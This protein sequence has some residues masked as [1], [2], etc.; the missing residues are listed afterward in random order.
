MNTE[1]DETE[2]V[3]NINSKSQP[4]QN[5]S[6]NSDDSIAFELGDKI[7]IIGGRHDNLKGRIYYIDENLIRVLPDGLS[8][9]LVDLPIVDEDIDPTLGVEK[10][11]SITKRANPAFVAQIDARVGLQA[12][13]FNENG[14]PGSTY[15]IKAVSEKDDTILLEDETG[16]E[17]QLEFAFRGIP[18][19]EPFD[20]IRPRQTR[21]VDLPELDEIEENVPEEEEQTL[22]V[23]EDLLDAEL[24]IAEI[25]EVPSSQRYY[26]DTV[27]RNDMLQEMI[28]A[29]DAA[30]QKNPE[31]Q[32]KIRS[33]VEQCILL[34]NSLVTY[35]RNGEP[36][37]Q[38]ATSY[39]T[40]SELL[41]SETIPLSRPVIQSKRI[42]FLD[43]TSEDLLNIAQGDPSQDPTYVPGADVEIKY[44]DT[45]VNDTVKYMDGQLGGN[46]GF[47][48]STDALPSWYLSWE[49]MNKQ[50]NSTWV[51]SNEI[52]VFQFKA[53]KEFLRGIP[54]EAPSIDGLG[55]LDHD[56]QILTTSDLV[57]KIGISLMRGLGP[58]STRLRQKEPL[59]RIESGEEGGLI[60][61]LLFPLSE[62]R[63]LG[64]IRSGKIAK[65]IAHSHMTPQTLKQVL[66]RLEGIPDSASAGGILSIGDGGNTLGNIPLD[67]WLRAL[68]LYPLGLGD[69]AVDLANY[70]LSYV[71]INTD[72]HDVIVEK[73]N[74]YRALIKQFITDVRESSTKELSQ[75]QSVPNPFLT[76]DAS[77]HLLEILEG[78]PLIASRIEELKRRLPVYKAIDLAIFAGLM[79]SSADL[80]LTTLAQIPGPLARERNRNV[81]DQF[82]AA[83]NNA[84]A[85]SEKRNSA[86]EVP[87]PNT[88]VHVSSYTSIQKIKDTT[89]KMRAFAKFLTRFQGKRQNNWVECGVCSQHL[90]C[91]HEV[92]LLQEFLHPRE[93]DT[94]HKELLLN[95]SGG[96][97]HGG[98]MCK[99]CGQQISELE[100]D[101]N[102]E[103]TES[104]VP[105]NGGQ[106]PVEE[107][108]LDDI[109][110]S[111]VKEVLDFKTATQTTIY[112]TTRK[113]FDVMGINATTN[114]YINI[115]QRVEAEILR[116]PS[117]EDYQRTSKGKRVVDYDILVNRI[118]V[119]AVGANCL[120]EIQTNIPGY[121]MRSKVPGCRAGFS[122]YPLGNEKDRT[123]IEYVSCVIATIQEDA[124]PW[125][126]TGFQ[127]ES[128]KKRTESIL[129][130]VT[131]LM[132]TF[133][134]NASVQQQIATK[135]AHLKE[136][137]GSVLYSEQLPE[138]I[139]RGFMPTPYTSEETSE[140]A[141]VPESA[142]PDQVIRAWVLQAHREGKENGIFVKGMPYSEA[143]CCL[144]EINQPGAFWKKKM[145]SM[146]TL[147]VKS[148]PRG[149]IRSHLAIH[150]KPRQ[151]IQFEGT[152]S[153]EVMYKIFLN[154]CY[155]GPRMG[156]PHQPGYTNECSSC[157][158][159]YPEN[160]YTPRSIPPM[161]SDR[162]IQKAMMKTYLEELDSIVTKGK[163]ALE[164]QN[165]TVS[166]E[167]FEEVVDAS[168]KA[169]RVEQPPIKSPLT[170]MK[171]FEQFA[172]LSPEPFFGW[173]DIIFETSERLSRLPPAA[174]QVEIAE[175]YGP[176]SNAAV[177]IIDEF[178]NRLGEVN[179]T[180]IKSVLESGPTELVESVR[181]Y[182]LIPFQRIISGFQYKLL[183]IQKSYKLGRGTEDDIHKFLGTH[184]EY[185]VGLAKRT[186]GF[187]LDKMK[188][189]VGRLSQSLSLLKT[190]IRGGYIPGGAMGLPFVTTALIGGIL[191]EFM[192][193][194]VIPPNA[195]NDTT[196]IDVG[197]RAPIQIIDVC[198][199][200]L[201]VEGLNFTQEQIRE[202]INR[203]T[204]IESKSF[205]GRFD[206]LTPEE[207]AAE[208]MKKRLGLGEWA[209]GGTKAIYAYDAE[210]YERERIQ[211]ID[212]GFKDFMPEGVTVPEGGE[213]DGY[214]NQQI[215]EDDY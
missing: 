166:Q 194:N 191:A 69:I 81:R 59:R 136:L 49:I 121:V 95:F 14:E 104:G 60:N 39:L 31:T 54:E 150:F 72:Q 67:E 44:L 119:G 213:Q 144:D 164:T 88:C 40:L 9:R 192:N 99:N 48:A 122:G 190:S 100:F 3:P 165:I 172:N 64:S 203:R 22:D 143:A 145:S 18:L 182:F 128:E 175:A 173:K 167:T 196:A 5:K 123:G 140:T 19:D 76:D 130:M 82:L 181:T 204:E 50:F 15:T 47:N 65:D 211:R 11:Y 79:V 42:L 106:I 56:N 4:L 26:P 51:S 45:V 168:H 176:I 197:A 156:L 112:N 212:M 207:K 199:Q 137:Y 35:N 105:M 129:A 96:Q 193:P 77:A 160:P 148:P 7:L 153:P 202:M 111:N 138:Q 58:R 174:D 183:R 195:E 171:L 25:K 114:T 75:L 94:L 36:S 89:L 108:V 147:P 46:N 62:Q 98:Y 189:A 200:R 169:F 17:L 102:I 12:E 90:V 158:F 6:N 159:V 116:Q 2:V 134:T 208:L 205:I 155:T 23:F 68:P 178:K 215:V 43:H 187:T 29:L 66:E 20:V 16:G 161:S 34:R 71:E 115:V 214:D 209:V 86:G 124:A 157:G 135:R 87:T 107:D 131:R 1:K 201:R 133:L 139:P 170:G 179:A 52:D 37:G 61:T 80:L 92:L 210:Q 142:K 33:L 186:N 198:I 83:L 118:L 132:E 70:G 146:A 38:R 125:N 32:K 149:P 126:L 78:E 141:I 13:T 57:T 101:T 103:F 110:E 55:V 154:V 74:M 73:M 206:R 180:V 8:D 41:A 24:D 84:L 177:M 109:V 163:V 93:K 127:R 184:L 117:R 97:F 30:S 120:I 185:L 85:K 10:L 21:D 27:Q 28:S 91:Y 152:I 162:G 113:L 63:N 53:D 188:W 151:Q